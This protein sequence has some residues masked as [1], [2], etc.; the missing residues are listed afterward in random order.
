[1]ISNSR[2]QKRASALSGPC[3]GGKAGGAPFGL[4]DYFG[5]QDPLIYTRGNS[6][7]SNQMT[8]TSF[9][10]LT[11]SFTEQRHSYMAGADIRGGEVLIS[12]SRVQKR[13]SALGGPC[14]SEM[15]YGI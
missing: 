10:I 6:C 11:P 3:F 9:C 5:S 7:N 13:A 4:R 1:M 12:N 15:L 14:C 8:N 2:G